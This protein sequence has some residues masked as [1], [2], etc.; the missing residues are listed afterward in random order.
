M[1]R[2]HAFLAALAVVCLAAPAAAVTINYQ[3]QPAVA[4]TYTPLSG[5]TRVNFPPPS[6]TG[7]L[8][9]QVPL[10]LNYGFRWFGNPVSTIYVDQSG[11]VSFTTQSGSVCSNSGTGFGDCSFGSALPLT[12]TPSFPASQE[13][14]LDS[15]YAWWGSL[16]PGSGSVT[17]G[18]ESIGGQQVFTLDFHNIDEGDAFEG[19]YGATVS[20]KVRLFPGGSK[21]EVVYGSFVGSS[22]GIGDYFIVGLQNG[23][24]T[25]PLYALGLPCSGPNSTTFVQC[26]DSDFPV[27]T[28]IT[29]VWADKPDLEWTAGQVASATAGANVGD[30]V[31]VS[32]T[33]TV[34]NDGTQDAG[35][36]DTQLYFGS[37]PNLSD[38]GVL[39]DTQSVTAL[40]MGASDPLTFNGSFTRPA[41]GKY[42]LVLVADP[43]TPLLPQGNIDEIDESNNLR[44][45]TLYMGTDLAGTIDAPAAGDVGSAVGVSVSIVN[46]GVDAV[47]AP[48]DYN[49]YM[50]PTGAD[51]G[52]LGTALKVSSGTLQPT[53]LPYNATLPITI[54]QNV[55]A[56]DF[57]FV[58]EIDPTSQTQPQGAIVEAD[59]TNNIIFTSHSTHARLPDLVISKVEAHSTASPNPIVTKAFFGEDVLLRTTVTNNG[60]ATANNFDVGLYL[61]GG[62]GA[63]V[64]TTFDEQIVDPTFPT[65]PPGASITFD[66][67]V[68]V[69]TQ[70]T[71]KTPPANWTEGDFFFGAIADSISAIGETNEGNNI[72]K[73]GPIHIRA[74]GPD[75]TPVELDVPQQAGV[76]EVVPVFRV[77]RNVGNLGNDSGTPCP[78]RYYLSANATITTEDIPLQILVNGQPQ[79]QGQVQLAIGADSRATE[80]VQ[81]PGNI[82]PGTYHLGILVN[83]DLTVDE[84]DTTNDALD[85][86]STVAVAASQLTITTSDLPDGVAGVPYSVQLAASGGS[87]F[88]WTLSQGST[89]PTGLTLSSSGLITGTPTTA[90]TSS[91]VATV[92]SGSLATSANFTLVVTAI[93]GPIEV[94][95]SQPAHGRREPVVQRAAGSRGRRV[96]VHLDHRRRSPAARHLARRELRPGARRP[97]R[98]HRRALHLHRPGRRRHGRHR[99]QPGGAARGEPQLAAHHHRQPARRRGGLA[100]SGSGAAGFAG[101]GN[102]AA[103]LQRHAGHACLR[104]WRSSMSR[105]ARRSR[106]RPRRLACTRSRSASPT[107]MASSTCTTTPCRSKTTSST[108]SPKRCPR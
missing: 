90:G 71:T 55:P 107:R 100:L 32:V 21:I 89:L 51:G 58:L 30:P 92:A 24:D 6:T 31:T 44:A 95:T 17:Y 86:S 18:L 87:S 101:N 19:S 50:S 7:S 91:F 66:T 49:I 75:F 48:F 81:L 4:E 20:F 36:F 106:A 74:P 10:P 45:L 42:Y 43:G 80:L 5:G 57:F 108:S 46:Q 33:G 28:R 14:P 77:I 103:R 38:G 13:Y 52:L 16:L 53:D 47:P 23:A 70:D 96:A 61:S 73:V 12:G 60:E 35:A 99:L 85:G 72:G 63:S 105:P 82:A 9:A 69:P 40:L 104:A 3:V 41:T 94:L 11:F 2:L 56:T 102:A 26:G 1:T 27:N 65:L 88:T 84:I 59:E 97:R 78:Y 37:T 62:L 68:T 83:P 8:L 39:L 76:G 79:A 98:G 64:I 93:T 25:S 67:I 54:P 34:F 29:Y 22:F 15:L